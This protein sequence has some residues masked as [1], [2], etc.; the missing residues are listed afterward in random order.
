M[1]G[2]FRVLVVHLGTGFIFKMSLTFGG[3]IPNYEKL[4]MPECPK[5]TRLVPSMKVSRGFFHWFSQSWDNSRSLLESF[6]FNL[7]PMFFPNVRWVRRP[8]TI[9]KGFNSYPPC[10]IQQK[11]V[12]GVALGF[13]HGI[14]HV[15]K[16]SLCGAGR[17]SQW[18][19][20]ILMVMVMVMVMMMMM[21]MMMITIITTARV[22]SHYSD[23][24]SSTC[25]I[26]III[27][28]ISAIFKLWLLWLLW[29]THV[30]SRWWRYLP[31]LRLGSHSCGGDWSFGTGNSGA[32]STRRD[33]G[34]KSSPKHHL[35]LD[36][37]KSGMIDGHHDIYIYI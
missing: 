4:M 33:L 14:S 25:I 18:S 20:M 22:F 8:F 21:M 2:I 9:P 7:F 16:T 34:K 23:W 26:I 6:S 36:T 35:F 29:D 19:L 37:Q 17:E 12:A 3:Y 24:D 30:F 31:A 13:R 15:E 11:P 27:I 28:I 32:W 5:H 10:T 1:W